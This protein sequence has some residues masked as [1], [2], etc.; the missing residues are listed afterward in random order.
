MKTLDRY[1]VRQFLINFT[2]TLV[3]LLLMTI[4][5]DVL[6]DLDEYLEGGQV[7][8]QKHRGS[9]LWWT[10]ASIVHFNGPIILL[11]YTIFSG[12]VVVAAVGFT[13][14]DLSRS[15]EL[16]AM[17]T[18]GIS[19][20]RIGAPVLIVGAIINLSSLPIKEYAIPRVKHK[21]LRGKADVAADT[22]QTKRIFYAADGFG[23]LIS[24]RKFDHGQGRLKGVVVLRRNASGEST[25]HF[26]ADD[27]KWDERRG[28]WALAN[29]RIMEHAL[30]LH[31]D[32]EG[33]PSDAVGPYFI[34]SDLSPN[35]LL[36]RHHAKYIRLLS[37]QELEVLLAADSAHQY[38]AQIMASMHSRFSVPVVQVLILVMA[39][40]FFMLREPA[41]PVAQAVKALLISF[42]AWIPSVVFQHTGMSFFNP[43]TAVWLPVV[44]YLPVAA[45]LAQRTKT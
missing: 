8:A 29:S 32:T 42:S 16:V 28:G 14:K 17:L 1:I 11:M 37:L 22:V 39:M 2:I 27:A 36:T 15:G 6:L 45:I 41:S 3:V 30:A 43:I 26:V 12:L 21:L 10:I 13:F 20:Y 18:S 33:Q 38:R 25:Q 24:A 34:K 44:M 5:I 23:N 35:V 7:R 40:P 9:V 4:L 19:M 31:E